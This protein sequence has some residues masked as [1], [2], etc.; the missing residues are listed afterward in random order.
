MRRLILFHFVLLGLLSQIPGG[1]RKLRSALR[2]AA[3]CIMA[4]RSRP[5]PP[6]SGPI[7]VIAPHQD[8]CTLGCGGLLFQTRLAGESVHVI[9]LTDGAA[10]HD[11]HP[12]ITPAQLAS[13]RKS[14]AQE[15]KSRIYVDSAC[16]TFMNLRDGQLPHLNADE[17]N[18]AVA[19]I[20]H[21]INRI[22]PAVIL[23]PFR[24]DGST[25]HEAG[26]LLVTAAIARSFVRP[27]LLE[28]P[29]WATY[30]PVHLIKPALFSARLFRFRFKGYGHYKRH[31]LAAY[32]S[33]FQPTPPWSQPVMPGDF[34]RCFERED[35]F[36]FEPEA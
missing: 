24:K 19:E 30:H 11:G 21:H 7:L 6:L 28:Y 3:Q 34:T 9:Y 12:V 20:E 35:E 4:L 27:R 16:L 18:A 31:A 10:S 23:L 13:I 36:F 17:R 5:L 14:E 22:A 2:T 33:Q 15:A 29:V 26:F 25:E 8:D 32:V 1:K